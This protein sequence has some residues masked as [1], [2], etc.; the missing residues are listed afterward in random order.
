MSR[1]SSSSF[2]SNCG[3]TDGQIPARG[4]VMSTT[5]KLKAVLMTLGVIAL[6]KYLGL[7][8]LMMAMFMADK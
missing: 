3:R 4:D 8:Q 7:F 5:D 6:A 1:Y 2:C